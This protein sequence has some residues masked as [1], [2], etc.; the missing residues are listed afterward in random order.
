MT[1]AVLVFFGV[2]LSANAEEGK[3]TASNGVWHVGDFGAKG[4]GESDNTAAFQKALDE[5]RE[6]GGGIVQVPAGRYRFDGTLSIPDDVSLRGTFAY[7]PAHAGIRDEGQEKPVFGSVLE[8]YAGAGSEDGDPFITVNG[9]ATLEGFTVHYPA[10]DPKAEAPTPYPYAIAMRGNNPAIIDVQLLNPF[11]GIDASQNQR[12]LIR[13]IHGQPIHIG[14]FVDQIYDIGRIENVHWNPWWSIGTPVYEWQ[15]KHG[16]GFLFGK[17]DWH[18]VL[19]TFCFGY[20]VGYKFIKTKKG[21]TNG[22]FLGIGA[23]DC[24]TALEVEESAPMGLL[25][26]NGEFV[27]FH[28]P[29]PTMIRVEKTHTGTVRFV[30][31]AFWGPA[32]RNAVIDGHGTVGFS[33]CSFMQWGHQTKGV[34]CIDVKGGSVLIRGCEFMEDKVQVVLG[35]DVER[36]IITQNLIA[37]KKRIENHSD[38]WVIVK[39]NAASPT[40]K[41][42]RKTRQKAPGYRASILKKKDKKKQPAP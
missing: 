38:G 23:D 14:V 34:P 16:V 1:A 42:W 22:N 19:N 13:N 31:C 37:G 35:K 12:A 15:L 8:P 24:Y 7:A 4:N 36:A 5:A 9:N 28:G 26:T 40:T 10:Q 25:I 3:V 29:D 11:N 21:S 17:T 30:N 27:S 33:D 39:D 32:N 6:A 2:I 41:K 18:Y 20:N